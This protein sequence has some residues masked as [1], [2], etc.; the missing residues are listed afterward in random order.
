MRSLETEVTGSLQ[1]LR[2]ILTRLSA[3]HCSSESHPAYDVGF[4]RPDCDP[5]SDALKIESEF[6][7]VENDLL[8]SRL[9]AY[10]RQSHGRAISVN[11]NDDCSSGERHFLKGHL[12]TQCNG[13][14]MLEKLRTNAELTMGCAQ[15]ISKIVHQSN[16]FGELLRHQSSSISS[17]ET[18][19]LDVQEKLQ[20]MK[21]YENERWQLPA[22]DYQQQLYNEKQ[23][24]LNNMRSSCLAMRDFF[25]R[26]QTA[27]RDLQ[28]I[29]K[30]QSELL[31]T[32][33]RR[34]ENYIHFHAF[35]P[36][37]G[38]QRYAKRRY[39]SE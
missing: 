25:D 13:Y 16:N 34:C 18:K 37:T 7:K 1:L 20:S 17:L 15:Q 39:Q 36:L 8:K 9:K 32:F 4:N 19:T 12:D 33:E 5:N 27:L 28:V 38:L 21:L 10:L 2:D 11:E 24:E 6:L 22:H 35:S 29:C 23:Q 31:E 3:G 26:S 14:S 30:L